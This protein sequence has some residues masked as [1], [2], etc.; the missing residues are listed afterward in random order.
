[1]PSYD[2]IP[3]QRLRAVAADSN[4]T[5]PA[6]VAALRAHIEAQIAEYQASMSR[7]MDTMYRCVGQEDIDGVKSALDDHNSAQHLTLELEDLLALLP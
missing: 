4:A 2:E 5:G 3:A 1:M 7:A 6:V